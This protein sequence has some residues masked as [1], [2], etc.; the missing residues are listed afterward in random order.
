[1]SYWQEH[2]IEE[3]I[4]QLMTGVPVYDPNIRFLCSVCVLHK[5]GYFEGIIKT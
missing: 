5:Q 4:T 2:N 3:K 1:M